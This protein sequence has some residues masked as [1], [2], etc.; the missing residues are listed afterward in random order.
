MLTIQVV[1]RVKPDDVDAF[2]SETI[3]NAS[4]SLL[5]PG[6][7]RFD[8]MRRDD[9]PTEFLL[10]EMYRTADDVAHHKTTAHY[11]RWR[12]AV[13]DMMAEPRRGVK[14]QL[15]FPDGRATH[16]QG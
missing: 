1:I 4:A 13:A 3:A 5:E 9:D 7:L 6:V 12:D 15:L 11:A 10:V 16:D 2:I 14:Y 8:F